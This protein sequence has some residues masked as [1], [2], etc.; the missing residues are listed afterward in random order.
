MA[1]LTDTNMCAE[2]YKAA[3]ERLLDQLVWDAI[4]PCHG[5]YIGSGGKQVLKAHLKLQ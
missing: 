5:Q 1:L 3:F 4:L 2:G